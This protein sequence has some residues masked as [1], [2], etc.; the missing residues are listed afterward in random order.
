MLPRIEHKN[1]IANHS[2]NFKVQ[3]ALLIYERVSNKQ[4]DIIEVKG[5][6]ISLANKNIT[7]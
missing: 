1:I 2:S 5:Q 4:V 7:L 6:N 3:C